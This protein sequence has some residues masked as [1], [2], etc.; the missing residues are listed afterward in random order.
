VNRPILVGVDRSEAATTA[1]EWAAHEADLRGAPLRLVHAFPWPLLSVPIDPRQTSAW[2]EAERLLEESRER[3][4]AIAARAEITAELSDEHPSAALLK[5]SAEAG[6][7]VVGTRGH[8][9]FAGLIIGSTA[10]QVAGHATV[11]VVVVGDRPRSAGGD[12]VVGVG[13][14]PPAALPAAAFDEATLHGARLRAVHAFRPTET[15]LEADWERSAEEDRI[16]AMLDTWR[17]EHAGVA[18]TI[19]V[20]EARARHALITASESARLLVLGKREHPGFT[21]SGLGSVTHSV[22]HNAR[23]PV[24]IV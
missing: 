19:E 24:L 9:G 6:L 14:K 12:V 16:T 11:P 5:R 13:D 8:G 20:V 3:A 23:C 18:V 21:T 15:D 22:I 7:V 1:L 2:A 4:A 10:L 17:K